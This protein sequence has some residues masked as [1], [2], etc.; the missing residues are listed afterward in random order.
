M[1]DH[2]ATGVG[3]DPSGDVICDNEVVRESTHPSISKVV[4][5]RYGKGYHWEAHTNYSWFP[6][7]Y[8]NYFCSF[9]CIMV[10]IAFW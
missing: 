8:E 1:F 2:Q 6:A 9:V 4:E 5:V 3:Y 7:N 10:D